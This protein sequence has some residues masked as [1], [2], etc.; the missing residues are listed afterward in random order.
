MPLGGLWWGGGA[1]DVRVTAPH[2]SV[3]FQRTRGRSTGPSHVGSP[4]KPVCFWIPKQPQVSM[5]LTWMPSNGFLPGPQVSKLTPVL[6]ANT[7]GTQISML[8]P[9]PLIPGPPAS[10]LTPGPGANTRI[11][12]LHAN[13][14]ATNT[15]TTGL[16]A[17]P[18]STN[19][20]TTGLHANP[21][22]KG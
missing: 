19:T 17:N 5:G 6:G 16:H 9:G 8:T 18:R 20:G 11:T 22:S 15:G 3:G 12:G 2:N 1:H 13:P 14:R 7:P 4:L 21:R 10:M